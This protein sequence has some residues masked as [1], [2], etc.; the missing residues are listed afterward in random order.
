MPGWKL[1]KKSK[2]ILMA[3]R[4]PVVVLVIVVLGWPVYP[5][6]GSAGSGSSGDKVWLEP[7]VD[8]IIPLAGVGRI[9]VAAGS[10]V[11]L[12]LVDHSLKQPW[13]LAVE[14]GGVALA[15]IKGRSARVSFPDGSTVIGSGRFLV[16]VAKGKVGVKVLE[17]QVIQSGPAVVEKRKSGYREDKEQTTDMEPLFEDPFVYTTSMHEED[18]AMFDAAVYSSSMHEVPWDPA[19]GNTSM[20]VPL[21]MGASLLGP[22][23]AGAALA[24]TAALLA[25]NATGDQQ[26]TEPASP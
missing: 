14:R 25:S 13:R 4:W 9:S 1:K 18:Q 2:L 10:K 15:L 26:A 22:A 6:P 24:S 12:G 5:Q 23:T 3:V 17:G 11:H 7:K 19:V 21:V 16:R 20:A 8:T